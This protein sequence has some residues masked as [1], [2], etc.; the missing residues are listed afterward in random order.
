MKTIDFDLTTDYFVEVMDA[1]HARGLDPKLIAWSGVGGG[2]P[3][4]SITGE[5]EALK[6]ALI[7]VVG[8][9]DEDAQYHVYG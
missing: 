2:N 8:M 6:K 9:D 4:V 1:M 5:P 3:N 7:E